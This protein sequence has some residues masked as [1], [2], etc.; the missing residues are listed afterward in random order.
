ML[1]APDADLVRR[2]PDLPGL[3]IVLDPEAMVAAL[4]PFLPGVTIARMTYVRYKPGKCCVV[5]HRLDADGG[6]NLYA[7]TSPAGSRDEPQDVG[8][9]S[10]GWGPPG[11]GR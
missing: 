1:S 4:H 9:R 11:P 5:A 8:E 10:S 6:V 7:K 2:D 3:S